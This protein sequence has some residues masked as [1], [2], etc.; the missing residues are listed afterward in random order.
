MRRRLADWICLT[1]RISVHDGNKMY[2]HQ[3]WPMGSVGRVG[4]VRWSSILQPT[5][6]AQSARR[7]S[8]EQT[9]RQKKT[10][11]VAIV[12]CSCVGQPYTQLLVLNHRIYTP[13]PDNEPPQ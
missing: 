13:G 5:I 3:L 7:G 1:E 2:Y 4:P 12:E 10:R 11:D 6:Q 8:D 9:I